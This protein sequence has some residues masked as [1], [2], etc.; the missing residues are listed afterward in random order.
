MRLEFPA[1][2]ICP[3]TIVAMSLRA[4]S[5]GYRETSTQAFLHAVTTVLRM[6]IKT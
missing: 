3:S 5:Q 4:D 2:R 1:L 6:N